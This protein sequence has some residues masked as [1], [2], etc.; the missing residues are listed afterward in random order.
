MQEDG[1][2]TS[3]D[4]AGIPLLALHSMAAALPVTD[5]VIEH[6]RSAP[7]PTPV[8]SPIFASLLVLDTPAQ[9]V[10]SSIHPIIKIDPTG[11][12][13]SFVPGSVGPDGR[14]QTKYNDFIY[15]LPAEPT[16]G[17]LYLVTRGR[18]VGIFI[19]WFVSHP[20]YSLKC[21][22]D[23]FAGSTHLRMSTV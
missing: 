7:P 12:H 13:S 2:G 16:N 21:A 22:S 14:I 11:P 23:V 6:G 18:R 1:N 17:Q 9:P 4:P 8:S 10:P 15:D 19:T 3:K 20:T 5:V